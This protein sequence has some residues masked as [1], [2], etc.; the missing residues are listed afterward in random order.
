MRGGRAG[1][2]ALTR[3]RAPRPPRADDPPRA[4]AVTPP[5][6]GDFAA[7]EDA[8]DLQRV[9]K[10]M[11]KCVNIFARRDLLMRIKKRELKFKRLCF[12]R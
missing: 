5:R 12:T 1:A 7:G 3:P 11:L 10:W 4:A 8:G 2:A 6:A 9:N